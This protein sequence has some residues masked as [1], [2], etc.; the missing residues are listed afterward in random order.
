MV[1]QWFELAQW[2]LVAIVGALYARQ[3]WRAGAEL[4]RRREARRA[5]LVARIN[6]YAVDD[7]RPYDAAR[8]VAREGWRL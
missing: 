5:E 1:V 3:E 8:L 4:A 2:A 6:R 7:S